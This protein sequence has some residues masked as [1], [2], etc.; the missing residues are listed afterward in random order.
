MSATAPAA[1]RSYLFIEHEASSKGGEH[2]EKYVEVDQEADRFVVAAW[3]AERR[4]DRHAD[5]REEDGEDRVESDAGAEEQ[6]Q[7]R[8][9]DGLARDQKRRCGERLAGEDRHGRRGRHQHRLERCL[10]ALR[11]KRA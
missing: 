5:R 7:G 9:H 4:L 10:L 3:E 2:Y 6:R 1:A 11:G 8:Q